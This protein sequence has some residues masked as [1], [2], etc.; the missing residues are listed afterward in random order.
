MN[1]Y[2]VLE[3]NDEFHVWDIESYDS[4]DSV[5]RFKN[6]WM[7]KYIQPTMKIL[8]IGCGPGYTTKILVDN[9]IDVLGI[10]LNEYSISK[11]LKQ[12][13]PVLKADALEFIH[14]RGKEFNFF[15]MSDFVE[16]VPLGV[17]YTILKQV[18][19]IPNAR[20]FL[21]TPNLDSLMGFKFW[22]HMP[23]HINAMHPYVIRKMLNKLGYKI[24][25]EWSEYGSL[26]GTGWK[27]KLR[28]KILE[29]LL[30]TQSQLF[31]GG[32]NINFIA[33]TKDT[34]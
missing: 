33:K 20:I 24:E 10:D 2:Y 23:T 25:A 27:Y 12:N 26:P 34:F 30:G 28:K 7:V 16:H 5:A 19:L 13:L 4:I 1:E 11:A 21:C 8:D 29:L 22:F 9:K 3:E 32:A 18:S 31:L 15:L 6:S 14:K 17:V